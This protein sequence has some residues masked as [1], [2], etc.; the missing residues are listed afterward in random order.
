[1][2]NERK[3]SLMLKVKISHKKMKKGKT[4]LE[5]C[6]FY[7]RVL[8]IQINMDWEA[9][10]LSQVVF[11]SGDQ[12]QI[13]LLLLLLLLLFI[14]FQYIFLMVIHCYPK[15]KEKKISLSS[16]SVL[17]LEQLNVRAS[18]LD[19]IIVIKWVIKFYIILVSRIICKRIIIKF[20]L[21]ICFWKR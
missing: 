12:C 15:V 19:K 11:E 5:F 17:T 18:N 3:I 6:N 14:F 7:S 20:F 9:A 2:V 10:G 8:Q 21:N 16:S 4:M 13:I 1:M